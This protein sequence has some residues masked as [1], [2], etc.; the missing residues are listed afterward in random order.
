M[1]AQT[2]AGCGVEK[3]GST[4]SCF[5]A[6]FDEAAWLIAPDLSHFRA[7]LALMLSAFAPKLLSSVLLAV[8][9]CH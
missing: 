9:A 4:D 8:S 1:R 2:Q 3:I 7:H 6:P 5:F